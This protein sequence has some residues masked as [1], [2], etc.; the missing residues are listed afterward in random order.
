MAYMDL[1]KGVGVA[2]FSVHKHCDRPV[3]FPGSIQKML[4]V[5]KVTRSGIFLLPNDR[6]SAIWHFSDINY[7]GRSDEENSALLLSLAKIYDSIPIG[8]DFKIMIWNHRRSKKYLEENY[9]YSGNDYEND[10]INQLAADIDHEIMKK[11][12]EGRNGLLQDKYILVMTTRKSLDAAESHFNEIEAKL[13]R[14]L[15]GIGSQVE[16]VKANERVEMLYAMLNPGHEEGFHFS[17]ESKNRMRDWRDLVCPAAI[18][19][20]E[21]EL[22]FPD[23]FQRCLSVRKWPESGI[24]DRFISELSSQPYPLLITIDASQIEFGA[25]NARLSQLYNSVE[26]SITKEK[27]HA[28][29]KGIVAADNFYKTAESNEIRSV[30]EN[31]A[32]NGENMYFCGVT[33]CL[34]ADTLADLDE[35]TESIKNMGYEFVLDTVWLRQMEAFVTALPIGLRQI[36]TM[37]T[38]LSQRVAALMP[39]ASMDVQHP[40]GINYGINSD[41]KQPI[42]INRSLL[43]NGHGFTFGGTGSGKSF[44]GKYANQQQIMRCKGWGRFI[45]IDPQGEKERMIQDNGG[46]YIRFGVTSPYRMNPLEITEGDLVDDNAKIDFLAHKINFLAAL[47]QLLADFDVVGAYANIISRCCQQMY[48]KWFSLEK[49]KRNPGKHKNDETQQAVILGPEGRQPQLSDFYELLLEQEEEEA[50]EIALV[51][52]TMVQGPMAIFN[53]QSTVEINADVIGFGFPD[54]PKNLMPTALLVIMEFISIALRKN[55]A[56]KYTTYVDIE[57]FHYVAKYDVAADY[58]V[59]WYKMVRK[60]SGYLMATTQNIVDAAATDAM[61]TMIANSDLLILMAMN[62]TD[63]DSLADARGIDADLL[64]PLLTAPVG[65]GII[66]YG[67]SL[68]PFDNRFSE[69]SKLFGLW[70]T[71]S[72]DKKRLREQLPQ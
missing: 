40:H 22:Q 45:F 6:Y 12:I 24:D 3:P 15:R 69:D 50:R 2:D 53:C 33:I 42:W 38:L 60:M 9:L 7:R 36:D 10:Q 27:E 47:V 61:K 5:K 16:R 67:T 37:Q 8:D 30:M 34:Q 51:L 62:Q 4:Q 20:K 58:F 66:L 57:E 72:N 13:V 32:N 21:N 1:F 71:D 70:N 52:E 14:D 11:M 56:D 65:T 43:K 39:F 28:A 18:I 31:I 44:T 64:A 54:L 68:I 26:L 48:E 49:K 46:T 25:V 17:F 35:R 55:N 29:Q 59:E 23:C 19:Q 63:I 41:S